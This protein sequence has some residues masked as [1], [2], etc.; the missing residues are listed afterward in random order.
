M[1]GFWLLLFSP[2]GGILGAR[3]PLSPTSQEDRLQSIKSAN[4]QAV[5]NTSDLMQVVSQRQG[6]MQRRHVL[7][8]ELG[9]GSFTNDSCAPRTSYPH[10]RSTACSAKRVSNK[11]D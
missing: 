6:G 1:D 2:P 11:R 8:R 4:G 9:R 5:R 10:R 3:D 7:A